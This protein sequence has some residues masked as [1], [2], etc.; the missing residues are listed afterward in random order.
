MRPARNQ[1][2][3]FYLLKH[4]FD[5]INNVTSASIKCRPISDRTGF[6]IYNAVQVISDYLC[7][8]QTY[9]YHHWYPQH[10]GNLPLLQDDDKGAS[11]DIKSLFTN[12]SISKT[13]DYSIAQ[14]YVHSNIK[15][16]W[17]KLIFKRLLLKL[18]AEWTFTFW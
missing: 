3:T 15:L 8:L 16:I 14:I 2:A 10:L 7:P 18:E 9:I 5:N 13:I 12:I 17:S 11:N 1:P 6:C 4:K